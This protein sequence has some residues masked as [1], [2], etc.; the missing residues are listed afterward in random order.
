ME[1]FDTGWTMIFYNLY[2][3]DFLI[4]LKRKYSVS[5]PYLSMIKYG[6]AINT[7]NYYNKLYFRTI[8]H[9]F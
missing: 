3:L 1:N 2:T 6:L 7:I 9:I 8:F 4:L 5:L